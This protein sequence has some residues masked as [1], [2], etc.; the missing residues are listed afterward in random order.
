MDHIFPV[1]D[2][3][4]NTTDPPVQKVVGPPAVIVG[5]TGIGFTV[6]LMTF[7][8]AEEHGPSIIVTE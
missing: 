1:L 4:V 3:E 7:E 8:E 6:T 2:E 5:A